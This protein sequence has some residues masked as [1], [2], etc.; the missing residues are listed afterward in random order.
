MKLKTRVGQI[1]LTHAKDENYTSLY[2]E[3]FSKHGQNVELFAVLEIS[4]SAGV[5]PKLRKTEYEHLTQTLVGAFKKTYVSAPALDQAT[6]EK[7]LATIN[8]SLSR[9][10]SRGKVGWYGKL[11]A[12]VGAVFQNQLFI[13]TTG[14]A[15]VYL[16]RK[17][18]LTLLSDGLSEAVSRPV[19]IFS[20]YSSGR[21]W[22]ADRVI[23]S[24]NQLVN[25]LSLDRIREFLNEDTLEEICQGIITAL[26]EI[27]TV[28]FATFV[29]EIG[30]GQEPEDSLGERPLGGLTLEKLAGRASAPTAGSGAGVVRQTGHYLWVSGKFLWELLSSLLGAIFGLV[31]TF[32]R[33]RPKKYLFLALGL[34][35]ILLLLN[36]G[37]AAFRKFSQ[38]RQ[39]QQAS[40][41]TE[42]AAKLDDAEAALIYNDE[43]RVVTLVQEAEKLLATVQKR[44]TPEEYQPLEKRL[45][46]L[47]KKVKKELRVESPTI[48]TQFPN[49]PTDLFYSP[50]G[51]VGFNRNSQS[52]AFY[53]FRSGETKS[54][55]TNQNTS[56]LLLGEFVG[57]DHQYVFLDKGGKLSSLKLPQTELAPYETESPLLDLGPAKIQAL[58]VLGEGATARLYLLDTRQN[59]IWRLRMTETGVETA[60]AWL[61]AEVPSVQ[62]AS[63]LTVDGSIYLQ[64]PERVEE[65][66]NGQRQTFALNLIEPPLKKATR[67]FTQAD[68]QF[69]YVLEPENSR[70]LLY[71]K[72]GKL[73]LQI[74][75]PKFRDLSD[76]YV[77]EGG[78]IIYALAGAELLQINY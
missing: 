34:V 40:A 10:A 61:K 28:G 12:A 71:S 69:L 63:D 41:V 43:D 75:S 30:T 11:N 53:D 73:N 17:G 76:I 25:Y 9:L 59:Q 8:A 29:C 22:T 36:V 35:V 58:A 26:N 14:S 47:Q 13:S 37:V 70:I 50:N 74:L 39:T 66:F 45:L 54:L 65:Y 33:K 21:V 2:E 18:E 60:E 19:K 68:Y 56:N 49:I 23:F 4:D 20:N 64:Y 67:I 15:L 31:L 16:S 5:S 55:L 78:K 42:M 57:G 48:L 52:L 24:T 27:K 1:F 72:D 6:F 46:E 7:A 32:F 77:D 38:N 51:A 62:E 3:A 44:S